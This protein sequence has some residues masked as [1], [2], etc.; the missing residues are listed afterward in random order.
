[1]D[2]TLNGVVLHQVIA[3]QITFDRMDLYEAW[4]QIG[5]QRLRW[6]KLEFCLTTGLKFGSSTFDPNAELHHPPDGVWMRVLN[7]QV[8]RAHDLYHRFVAR[9]Y[10]NDPVVALKIAMVVV[11]EVVLFGVDDKHIVRPW[12]WAL[13]DDRQRWDTFPWGK[14]VFSA[15]L[16]YLNAIVSPPPPPF[17]D[18]ERKKKFEYHFYGFPLAFQLECFSTLVPSPLKQT[19][20]YLLDIEQPIAEGIK[21]VHPVQAVVRT[22]STM[23]TSCTTATET[24][25]SN[26]V[27]RHGQIMKRKR[28]R[29]DEDTFA[30]CRDSSVPIG[31]NDG[32]TPISAD[33][34]PISPRVRDELPT[35]ADDLC[36]P[37]DGGDSRHE[38]IAE[39]S[40]RCSSKTIR[41]VPA[42]DPERST[43]I[44]L[45]TLRA[46]LTHEIPGIVERMLN[47]KLPIIVKKAIDDAFN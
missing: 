30:T 44:S 28:G 33:L 9:D 16:H 3:R 36:P 42:T 39:G 17:E 1:M 23:M 13:V 14:F 22:S 6:S 34:P 4:F 43:L 2:S 41:P 32:G 26:L 47:A 37:S 21:Y 40:I 25:S 20:G 18:P 38:P 7:G 10:N 45:D 8:I 29:I 31:H 19:Q 5:S 11:A 46:L 27:P 24:R 12:L 35:M 15:T